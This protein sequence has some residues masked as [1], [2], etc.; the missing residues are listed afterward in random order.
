MTMDD[1]TADH[2]VAVEP[3]QECERCRNPCAPGMACVSSD[4]GHVNA[5]RPCRDEVQ[6]AEKD[7]G[8]WHHRAALHWVVC[9]IRRRWLRRRWHMPFW[10]DDKTAQ[11]LGIAQYG[12]RR[13]GRGAIAERDSDA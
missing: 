5:E 10:A 6:I 9:P 2:D 13:C 3:L 4:P 12:C 11:M 7:A 8:R 1:Q